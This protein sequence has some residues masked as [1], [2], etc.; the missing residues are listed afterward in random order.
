MNQIVTL[1]YGQNI[2]QRGI[3]KLFFVKN[4][5]VA[6]SIHTIWQEFRA[7]PIRLKFK[8]KVKNDG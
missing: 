6:F 5:A 8:I 2:E 3:K 1:G 4:Y 7:D